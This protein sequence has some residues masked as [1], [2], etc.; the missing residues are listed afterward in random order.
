MK[1]RSLLIA[2]ASVLCLAIVG[3]VAPQPVEPTQPVT[4]SAAPAASSNVADVVEI[5][6]AAAL[7]EVLTLEPE[8]APPVLEALQSVQVSARRLSTGFQLVF[9]I[10]K[11]S[12]LQTM[13]AAGLLDQRDVVLV[14]GQSRRQG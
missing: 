1:S 7:A 6:T 12:P 8:H 13:L 3:C 11:L 14:G 5:S 4:P 10:G 2:T 9:G